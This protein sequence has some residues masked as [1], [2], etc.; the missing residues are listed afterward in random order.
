MPPYN[1]TPDESKGL[2]VGSLINTVLSGI[3]ANQRGAGPLEAMAGG[4]LS[5]LGAYSGGLGNVLD[6]KKL[7][8]EQEGKRVK[9]QREAELFPLQKSKLEQDL[10]GMGPTRARLGAAETRAAEEGKSKKLMAPLDRAYKK[11][12][13]KKL[14]RGKSPT[15]AFQLWL[16]RNP[17]GTAEE[18]MKLKKKYSSPLFG[19][20]GMEDLLSKPF[21]A[22]PGI[23]ERLF[24]G[25]EEAQ[26]S[27]EAKLKTDYT[28]IMQQYPDIA[29]DP[30]TANA[31]AEALEKGHSKEAIVTK[32][33]KDGLL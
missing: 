4:G 10:L 21:E 9:G 30:N 29:K 19:L 28:A 14:G 2:L 11:A 16:Q 8:E 17:D 31:I 27:P 5:G 7:I 24:G 1:L 15:S 32:L 26:V 3:V 22:Q 6:M 25:S 18:Y 23:W 33:R 12:Q 20:P 13:I